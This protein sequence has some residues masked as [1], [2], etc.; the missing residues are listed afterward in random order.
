MND[1][2]ES[3]TWIWNSQNST[4]T[5]SNM[6]DPVESQACI[7][8]SQYPRWVIPSKSLRIFAIHNIQHNWSSP[9][10]SLYLLFTKWV[11]LFTLQIKKFILTK[12]S[13]VLEQNWTSAQCRFKWN[14]KYFL[15]DQEATLIGLY[16]FLKYNLNKTLKM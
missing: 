7:Y 4:F 1:S 13:W 11:G 10:S 15:L 12:I 14:I 6:N 2:V 8:Y 3:Q 9:K 5:I 16:S